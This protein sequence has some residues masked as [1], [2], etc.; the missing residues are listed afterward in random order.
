MYQGINVI[1]IEVKCKELH[2]GFYTVLYELL[3]T[4]LHCY[5]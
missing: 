4:G 5:F 1:Y 3:K 2:Y